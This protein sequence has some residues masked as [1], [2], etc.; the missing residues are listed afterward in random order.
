MKRKEIIG[1]CNNL[2]D[3]F[4]N[5]GV[6]TRFVFRFCLQWHTVIEKVGVVSFQYTFRFSVGYFPFLNKYAAKLYGFNR[7]RFLV[8]DF[9]HACNT[10]FEVGNEITVRVVGF[11][12]KLAIGVA[13]AVLTPKKPT[14][15]VFDGSFTC[16]VTSADGCNI[17]AKI[18]C[19]I[20]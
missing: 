10:V 16:S 13:L 19:D 11:D 15:S 14:K 5:D 3:C 4:G 7:S 17:V 20:P 1:V 9:K 12:A 2:K 18:Y 6:N 8:Y